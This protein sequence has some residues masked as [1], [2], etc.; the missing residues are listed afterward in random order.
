MS[1]DTSKYR[2]LFQ[3]TV[4]PDV[5]F[6]KIGADRSDVREQRRQIYKNCKFFQLT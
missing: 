3:E 4:H 2:N 5:L 6:G 1:D